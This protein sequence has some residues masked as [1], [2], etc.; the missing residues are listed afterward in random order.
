LSSFLAGGSKWQTEVVA[1]IK[2]LAHEKVWDT[3]LP[4]RRAEA[5]AEIVSADV[6]IGVDLL[7]YNFFQT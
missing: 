3:P 6:P 2:G 1:A 7:F 4:H 5:E